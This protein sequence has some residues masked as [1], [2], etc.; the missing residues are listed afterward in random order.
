MSKL[1]IVLCGI[2]CFQAFSQTVIPL[3][4]NAQYKVEGSKLIS[5]EK[6]APV[7][8]CTGTC[9]NSKKV[10]CNHTIK[11]VLDF[12]IPSAQAQ[13]RLNDK[14]KWVLSGTS[15]ACMGCSACKVQ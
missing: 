1:I 8:N 12:I 13:V 2:F 15:A 14:C 4:A 9:S 10:G 3:K 11:T 6:A 7:L 5:S